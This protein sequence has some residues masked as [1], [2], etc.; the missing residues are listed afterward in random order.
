MSNRN[1]QIYVGGIGHNVHKD[2]LYDAFEKF[3]KIREV[4]FKNRYAFVVSRN[5]PI[6]NFTYFKKF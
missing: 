4:N 5:F 6:S 2:D 1:P 3:G